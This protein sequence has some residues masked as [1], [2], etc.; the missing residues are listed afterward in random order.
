[1][2]ISSLAYALSGASILSVANAVPA[3]GA[4]TAT[5]DSGVIV[6]TFTTLP[7]ATAVVHKYLG[8]PFADSPPERFRPPVVPQHWT[9]PLDTTKY[10]PACIQQFIGNSNFTKSIFNN[11]APEESEDCL[12]LNVFTPEAPTH[13]AGRAVLVWLYGGSLQ[14]G[15]ASLPGYDGSH[16]AGYCPPI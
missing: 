9:R 11:P 14:F 5:V 3:A 13:G 8:I 4:P 16:F 2:W 6:G 1:M 15:A 12:Y 7:S 10:K